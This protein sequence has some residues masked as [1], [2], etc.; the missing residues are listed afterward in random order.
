M[1]KNYFWFVC[2]A[3]VLAFSLSLASCGS[4]DPVP[5]PT[6]TPTPDPTPTVK[7]TGYGCWFELD[8]IAGEEEAFKALLSDSM[9]VVCPLLKEI[10]PLKYGASVAYTEADSS[11][12]AELRAQFKGILD[13]LDAARKNAHNPVVTSLVKFYS[14]TVFNVSSD[15]NSSF[16]NPSYTP[17]DIQIPDLRST[18]WSTED[19]KGT[20]VESV[21]FGSWTA[22]SLKASFTGTAI[23]N[24]TDSYGVFRQGYGI[25]LHDEN[26]KIRY[27]FRLSTDGERF[28]LLQ[29]GQTLL[30]EKDAPVYTVRATE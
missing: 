18:V 1:K 17:L 19:S 16:S 21:E 26:L 22:G 30:D 12:R 25:M 8:S 11:S 7:Y 3:L 4:D 9:K 27:G 2:M 14:E 15:W 20:G 28:L 24:G 13:V 5:D 29:D 6:P 23:V 10:A